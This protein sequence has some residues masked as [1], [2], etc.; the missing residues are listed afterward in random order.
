MQNFSNNHCGTKHRTEI[1]TG[2]SNIPY[3]KKIEL[4]DR[5]YSLA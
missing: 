1:D 4:K 2:L 3:M 5:P